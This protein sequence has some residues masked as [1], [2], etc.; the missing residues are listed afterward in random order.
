MNTTN[1]LAK[2]MLIL[3]TNSMSEQG[4]NCWMWST[5]S[6]ERQDSVSC[7]SEFNL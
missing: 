3:M 2:Q 4:T 5:L 1:Y 7:S 6:L